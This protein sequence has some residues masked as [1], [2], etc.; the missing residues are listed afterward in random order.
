MKG[1]V[2]LPP[3]GSLSP[4]IMRCLLLE[5]QRTAQATANVFVPRI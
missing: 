5:K 2:F 1:K 4:E 3:L